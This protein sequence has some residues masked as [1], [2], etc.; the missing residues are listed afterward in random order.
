MPFITAGL[1]AGFGGAL[2]MAMEVASTTW[3]PSGILGTFV[4]TAGPGGAVRSALVYLAGLLVSYLCSFAIT[5]L[6]YSERELRTKQTETAAAG[7]EAVTE[8]D[9]AAA[10]DFAAEP[11]PVPIPA[12]SPAHRTVRHGELITLGPAEGEFV[13]PVTVPTG[14]HARPAGRIAEIVGDY[15]CRMWM[16]CS[17]KTASALSP[18]ELMSLGASQGSVLS[19]SAEGKDAQAALQAVKAFMEKSL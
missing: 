16:S 4:M 11:S 10:G 7:P 8:E 18:I 12:A 1:G 9:D 13:F 2:V 15:H 3:G 6:F 19:V 14:L 17:G 5:G